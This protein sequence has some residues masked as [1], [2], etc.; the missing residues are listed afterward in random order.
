MP[1]SPAYAPVTGAALGLLGAVELV[2]VHGGTFTWLWVT[3]LAATVP[4]AWRSLYPVPMAYVVTVAALSS[5][6]IRP[7]LFF[8][9]AIGG[10]VGLYHL[11]YRSKNPTRLA[12]A[13]LIVLIVVIAAGR[14]W[15]DPEGLF[16]EPV[17]FAV[18]LIAVIS[19]ADAGRSRRRIRQEREVALARVVA[20]ERQ[21]AVLE[22]RARIAREL[23]DVVAHAVSVIAV[24]A[25]TSQYIEPG[26][27]DGGKEGFRR[28]AVSARS[29]LTELRQVLDVLRQESDTAQTTPQPTLAELA[30]L[31]RLHREAGERAELRVEGDPAELPQAVEMSAYR[32][33][34]EALTNARR[35]APG[36]TTH[37]TIIYRP[38]WV[39]VRVADD[40]GTRRSAAHPGP[41]GVGHGLLGMHERVA[42]LGGHLT[43]GPRDGGGFTVR[44]ELPAGAGAPVRRSPVSPVHRREHHHGKD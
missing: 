29:A 28:I 3:T 40:G 7:E 2:R 41:R 30:D 11:A 15:E 35:H 20:A 44:A 5:Y 34:Q 4:L 24:Q 14:R 39:T 32:I 1:A 33:V 9:V 36:A 19:L 16:G 26:L 13:A 10:L 12:V 31:V 23:H 25:E 8:A 38:A 17:V 27:T 18:S 6:V 42:M 37:V 21:Q 22:E 43:M